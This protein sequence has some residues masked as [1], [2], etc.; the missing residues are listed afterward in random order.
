MSGRNR[1]QRGRTRCGFTLVELLVVIGIIA[2]LIAILLPALNKARESARVVSCSSNLRNIGLAFLMYGNDNKQWLPAKI[3][4]IAYSGNPVGKSVAMHAGYQLEIMLSKYLGRA[5]DFSSSYDVT[6]ATPIWV[7]P[8]SSVSVGPVETR[9]QSSILYNWDGYAGTRNNTYAGLYY[10]ELMGGHFYSAPGV[11]Q[12]PGGPSNWTLRHY[13]KYAHQMPLQWCSTRGPGV[14]NRL[15][16]RS[17]HVKG[18]P[19]RELGSR[20]TLFM[21]GH[22]S[23]LR[24]R[25]YIG[26]YQNILSSNAA[27]NIHAW[28]EISTK[29]T[30]D[31]RNLYGGGNRYG[32][33]EY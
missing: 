27:P 4:D 14:W 7:C 11:L 8:S 2:V 25:Y 19:G 10:T 3:N 15:G 13:R 23:A 16:A 31:G 21:D 32:L 12:T 22:V 26:D 1:G 17:W 33:S 18:D 30:N 5:R 9:P 6:W 20:P 28:F 29:A 24:S